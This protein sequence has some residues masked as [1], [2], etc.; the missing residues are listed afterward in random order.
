M[1]DSAISSKL[2]EQ[3]KDD[4][5]GVLITAPTHADFSGTKQGSHY[6]AS[7]TADVIIE[8]FKEANISFN[9]KLE[10]QKGWW[11]R[12]F[13][14]SLLDKHTIEDARTVIN[15]V[16]NKTLDN[17]NIFLRVEP[18]QETSEGFELQRDQEK[19]RIGEIVVTQDGETH[20]GCCFHIWEINKIN[21]EFKFQEF[22]K[23]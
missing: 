5:E 23:Y 16:I 22:N 19:S 15:S 14:K 9:E 7:K 2:Y 12:F 20:L 4:V 6:Y 17:E 8:L 11:H 10:E 18:F 21:E 3:G 13:N 1:S